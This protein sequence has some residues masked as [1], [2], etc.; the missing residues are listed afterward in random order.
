[1]Y[2]AWVRDNLQINYALVDRYVK[3]LPKSVEEYNKDL[4]GLDSFLNGLRS[5]VRT[6]KERRIINDWLNFWGLS[7]DNCPHLE[8]RGVHSDEFKK[9]FVFSINP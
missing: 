6:G 2:L 1:M 5:I 4:T 8:W 9:Q 3:S 7:Y